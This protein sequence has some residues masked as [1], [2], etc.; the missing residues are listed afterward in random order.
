[1]QHDGQLVLTRQL[2]LC[3]VKVLLFVPSLIAVDL[4]HKTIEPNFTYCDQ[5]RVGAVLLQGGI[6]L[7]Q[8][9]FGGGGGVERV[10]AQGIDIARGIS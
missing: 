10:N 4:W 5:L 3:A 6:E 9:R 2:Q 1:M 8:M 7:L